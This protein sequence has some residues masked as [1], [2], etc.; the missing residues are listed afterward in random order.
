MERGA[1]SSEAKNA[2]AAAAAAKREDVPNLSPT[3]ER[4]PSEEKVELAT[5]TPV[6]V[7]QPES[8]SS[9]WFWLLLEQSGY[10]R[11]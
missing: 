8:E 3:A 5:S 10:E 11:W 1:V 2:N 9:E 6:D 7:A 4:G